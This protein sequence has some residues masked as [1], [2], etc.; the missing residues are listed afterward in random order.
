[1][2]GTS[3]WY[4]AAGYLKLDLDSQWYLAARGD[5]FHAIVPPGAT[6]LFF[7]VAWVA[8]GTATVAYQPADGLSFRFEYRHD[9]APSDAYFG[10]T[11]SSDPATGQ[12]TPNR[13]T[14]NTL[15]LGAVASF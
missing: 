11:V 4:A 3:A 14:Q 2:F 1:V 8:E 7:P 9:Q 15:T 6:P 13:R 12:A 5:Y 10:G